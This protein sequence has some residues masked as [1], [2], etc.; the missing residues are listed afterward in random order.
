MMMMMIGINI[1][2]ICCSTLVPI[3]YP[4][5][6]TVMFFTRLVSTVPGPVI[7]DIIPPRPWLPDVLRE[8]T[9]RVNE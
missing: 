2:I 7:T 6:F 4:I 5:L 3:S 1:I 9:E 8:Y